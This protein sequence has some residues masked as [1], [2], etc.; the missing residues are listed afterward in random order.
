M[1]ARVAR[2]HAD[3]HRGGPRAAR[4]E[5]GAERDADKAFDSFTNDVAKKKPFEPGSVKRAEGLAKKHAG[6][7]NGKRF[8]RFVAL[9]KI[10]LNK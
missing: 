4:L 10:D 9:A 3:E 1:A 6:T 2:A 8:E 7:K 5:D